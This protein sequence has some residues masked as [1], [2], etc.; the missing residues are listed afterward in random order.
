M[1]KKVITG[2]C[3]LLVLIILGGFLYVGIGRNNLENKMWDYLEQEN[4]SE[5]DI[6]SLEV[7]HSF[8]NIL[9]SYNEWTI[10]VVYEDEPTSVYKYTFALFLMFL[11]EYFGFDLFCILIFILFLY[12]LRSLY[13]SS[14]T[15][16]STIIAS[17]GR[18]ISP[19]IKHRRYAFTLKNLLI[20]R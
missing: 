12:K 9:L 7:K 19:A 5:T 15:N 17:N 16:H 13:I 1:K 6:Q 11:A 10:E 20:F 4:Y 8:M 14:S 2:C 18:K 3:I